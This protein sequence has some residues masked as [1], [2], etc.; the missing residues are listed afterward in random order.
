MTAAADEATD[1]SAVFHFLDTLMVHGTA[2]LDGCPLA[3]AQ[4]EALGLQSNGREVVLPADWDPLVA[5]DIRAGLGGAAAAWLTRLDVYP[6]I[7]ST[8]AELTSRA[9]FEPIAGHVCLAEVQLAGRG[10]R[11]RSW[12]SPLGGSLALS[13][14]FVPPRPLPELGAFSL[15]IGLAV[16]DALESC[17][18]EGLALKWPNDVLLRGAKLGGILIELVSAPGGAAVV[19]GVGINVRLPAAAR[20]GIEQAVTDLACAVSTLPRRS[21]LA[22]RLVDCMVSFARF[23]ADSG[24]APFVPSFDRRHAYQGAEVVLFQ[25][26]RAL[27]ARVLGVARDGGLRIMT[28]EGE[29]T[30]HG[31]EVS[32]RARPAGT[33]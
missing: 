23:F 14:G 26:D 11:G 21:Y 10:R 9:Q 30:V 3:G 32:L 19:V 33:L 31:G 4:M 13:L 27:E 1:P 28:D 5:A 22:A 18:V 7:G 12:Q 17:G 29:Q 8:N 6:A 25:G 15:V 16:L 24:F 2:P 20:L